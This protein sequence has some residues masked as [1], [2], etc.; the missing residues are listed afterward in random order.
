M[1]GVLVVVIAAHEAVQDVVAIGSNDQLADR[2]AHI[3]RQVTGE[4]VAEVAGGYRERHGARRAAEL[5]GR[6]EVVDDL[7]HD[8]R[9]VDRVDRNQTGALEEAL[10]GEAGLDHLLA[11]VEVTFDGNVMDVVAKDAGHL[12]T[13]HL[14]HPVVRVHDEDVDI[15]ASLAAFNSRRA[16]VTGGRAH[17]DHALAALDQEV[18][19]QATQQLQGKVLERQGRAVEQL[20]HPLVAVQLTKRRDRLVLKNAVGVLQNLFEVSIRNATGNKRTHDVE[21]QLVVRQT[22]PGRNLLLGKTRQILRDVQTTV[23]SQTGQQNIFKIQGR[24]LATGTDIAHYKTLQ[25]LA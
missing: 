13:L 8:A 6:V 18:V 2:Q 9:P 21:R 25:V 11:V 1:Q 20:H 10:I 12:A 3:A 19:E 7:R 23:R 17:D 16:G 5:Q 24:S 15:L 4:D 14:G 22:G